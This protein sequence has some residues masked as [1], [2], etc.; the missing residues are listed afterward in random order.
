[1][2]EVDAGHLRAIVARLEHVGAADCDCVSL[3]YVARE[4]VATYHDSAD[5]KN[6]GAA[7][8][9]FHTDGKTYT[10]EIK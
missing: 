1:M 8:R 6:V 10:N 2:I 3:A 5:H 7:L 4:L 9:V